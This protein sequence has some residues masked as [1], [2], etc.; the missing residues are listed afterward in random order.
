MYSKKKEREMEQFEDIDKEL[1]LLD[2][3]IEEIKVYFLIIFLLY[4]SN[5]TV[6]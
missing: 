2:A 6:I 3:E 5:K 1:S 4:I